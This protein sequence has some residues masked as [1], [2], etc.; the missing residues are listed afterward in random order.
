MSTIFWSR[1]LFHTYVDSTSAGVVFYVGMGDDTRIHR[2]FGRNKRHT[3]VGR[4][5]GLVRRVVQSFEDR[6]DALDFE[7][8]LIAEHHTYVDDPSY[9]GMGCNYTRGGEGC[10]CSEETRRKISESRKGKPAW[11]KGKP[12]R[13]LTDEEK[14]VAREQLIAWNK[15]RPHLGRKRS[16]ETRQKMR[17]PHCCSKCGL[18]GHK[19]TTCST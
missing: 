2:R 18:P 10:S 4:K 19:R 12:G 6:Q 1:S 8:K 14:L 13:R 16:E 3:H 5:H 11:N 15:S 17:H 7:V 9:N